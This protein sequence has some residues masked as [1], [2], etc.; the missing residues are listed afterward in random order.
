MSRVLLITPTYQEAQNIEEFLKRARVGLPE[1]DILVVDDNSPD[2]T[3]D[4][5]DAAAISLGQIEVL[6]RPGKAGLGNAYR[7]GFAIGLARGYEVLVQIDADL[8]HD[9]AV[10]PQL[11]AALDAGADL[12]IGSRYVPGGSIPNWPARRRALS[13]YGNAYTGFMLRTGVADATAGF[14]AY[15]AE[16]LRLIDYSAT[17]SKGYGF[18]IETAYRVAKTGSKIVEVPI[19][20]TDRVRGHSKMSLAVMVEEMIMVSWWGIRDRV[21]G[22]NYNS[23]E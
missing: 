15:K 5:A 3:A 9:P 16:V 23:Q 10:L 19:T 13:K 7:A 18:Q 1:A 4:L 22:R 14:R 17:R 21:L 20:F 12:A 2:G 6:R 8:S 11:I